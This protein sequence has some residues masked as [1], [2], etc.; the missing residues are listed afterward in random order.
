[1]LGVYINAFVYAY[2]FKVSDVRVM[3]RLVELLFDAFKE[4]HR[5]SC[6]HKQK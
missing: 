3:L 5:A 6:Y 4:R 1:M 2:G